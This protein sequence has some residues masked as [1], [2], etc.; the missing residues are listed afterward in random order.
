MTAEL[1]HLKHDQVSR[2]EFQ[3]KNKDL[4]RDFQQLLDCV[5]FCQRVVIFYS[6]I[7]N[8]FYLK[9]CSRLLDSLQTELFPFLCVFFSH[10]NILMC[11]KTFCI[12]QQVVT[13]LLW[14]RCF[15]S[16]CYESRFSVSDTL[17]CSLSFSQS[18]SFSTVRSWRNV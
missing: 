4:R 5:G 15:C 10:M 18:F 7:L 17:Y 9:C 8:I 6:L 1:C 12:S 14:F 11:T 3:V 16:S 2:D 13:W